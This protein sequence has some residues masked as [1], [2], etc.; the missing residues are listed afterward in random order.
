MFDKLM[1]LGTVVASG[2]LGSSAL[3]FAW[4]K[5]GTAAVWLAA[6]WLIWPSK[7]L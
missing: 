1:V 2:V 7:R 5:P 4:D 3:Y 6:A